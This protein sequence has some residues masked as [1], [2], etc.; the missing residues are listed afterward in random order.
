MQLEKQSIEHILSGCKST[1]PHMSMMELLGVVVVN[2]QRLV[3]RKYNLPSH[4]LTEE[5]FS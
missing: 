5:I 2:E 1:V 4:I 3:G